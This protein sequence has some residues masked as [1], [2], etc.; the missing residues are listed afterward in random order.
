MLQYCN[1]LFALQHC[2]GWKRIRFCLEQCLAL[3]E[4]ERTAGRG[5][6]ISAANSENELL[7]I[8]SLCGHSSINATG[9]VWKRTLLKGYETTMPNDW[10]I[11]P[12][13]LSM[14]AC[15]VEI[16]PISWLQKKYLSI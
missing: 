9:V 14:A 15:K 4:L 8:L 2:C 6:Q 11:N 7:L 1:G 5:S 10:E 12:I 3:V 13:P 16:Q